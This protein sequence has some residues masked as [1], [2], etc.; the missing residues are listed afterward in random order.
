L[1]EKPFSQA[2][3]NILLAL[4]DSKSFNALDE[5]SCDRCFDG[6][7]IWYDL[8]SGDFKNS[9]VLSAST[10]NSVVSKLTEKINQLKASFK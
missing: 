1:F 2:E 9:I 10:P 7:D 6:C 4:V 5:N 8:N 3:F